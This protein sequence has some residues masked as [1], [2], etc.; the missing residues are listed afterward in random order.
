VSAVINAHGQAI[1]ELAAK[2]SGD[3]R[4][5]A[6]GKRQREREFGWCTG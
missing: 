5:A 2:P 4:K 6:G 3:E 1:N